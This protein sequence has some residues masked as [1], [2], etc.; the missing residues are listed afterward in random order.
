MKHQEKDLYE[1]AK[2]Y[3]TEKHA[4]QT[5]KDGIGRPFVSHPLRAVEL[6]REV[7][8]IQDPATLAAAVLHDTLEDTNAKQ[9][10][11]EELF[12]AEV[13]GIVV[14]LTDDK[15]LPR[16]IRK[17][18][19]IADAARLSR[20]AALVRAADKIANAEDALYH[21]PEGWSLERRLEYLRWC[22]QVIYACVD[23]PLPLIGHFRKLLLETERA[24]TLTSVPA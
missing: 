9:E 5:R 20:K 4:H 8:G 14:Q 23:V 15:R 7:A 10:D 22:E 16:A 17:A 12:G 13:A 1:R 2:D 6:L 19:E 18:A 24:L 11:L 21:T 3:A